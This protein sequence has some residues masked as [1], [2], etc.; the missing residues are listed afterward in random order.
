MAKTC[1]YYGYLIGADQGI[2]GGDLLKLVD[3]FQL[4]KPTILP[5]VPRIL[6]KLYDKINEQMRSL[7]AEKYELF[8]KAVQTKIQIMRET[9]SVVHE[10]YDKLFFAKTKAIM[11]GRIQQMLLSSAPIQQ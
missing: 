8:N 3:D 1:L 7:G 4:L 11:G 9:G 5:M 6:N 10:E 2:F